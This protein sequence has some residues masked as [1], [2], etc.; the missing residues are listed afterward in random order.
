MVSLEQS[1]LYRTHAQ[2]REIELALGEFGIPYT[3][4][5]GRRLFERPHIRPLFDLLSFITVDSIAIENATILEIFEGIGPVSSQ[6]ISAQIKRFDSVQ[7]WLQRGPEQGDVPQR[8]REPIR[9]V[10]S[11]LRLLSDALSLPLHQCLTQMR[12]TVLEPWIRRSFDDVDAR[13]ADLDDCIKM[14][15][16]FAQPIDFLEALTLAS[17]TIREDQGVVLSTVH[18]AK[19]LEWAS[20]F[21]VGL[22]DGSFP[23]LGMDRG[24]DMAEERR[25]FYVA[26][27]R[28]Q[29]WL[30]LCHAWQ[31][32]TNGSILSPSRFLREIGGSEHYPDAKHQSDEGI[33]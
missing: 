3:L 30:Y 4:R 33:Q 11:K 23:L 26:L 6:E 8:L 13:L 15:M 10:H 31:E 12:Q 28:C 17:D 18:R 19:G 29:R 24:I 32:H 20:V 27:T 2:S 21:I 14:S 5:S 1:V 22:A 9:R 7:N 16:E 25:L